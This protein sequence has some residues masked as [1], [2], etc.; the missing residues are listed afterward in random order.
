MCHDHYPNLIVKSRVFTIENYQELASGTR[1]GRAVRYDEDTLAKLWY[2]AVAAYDRF[3]RH[4]ELEVLDQAISQFQTIFSS[5]PEDDPRLADVLNNLGNSL[6]FRFERLGRLADMN[7]GIE[8][9]QKV[10]NLIEDGHSNKPMYLNNLGISLQTRFDR[11]GNV[12]DLDD[13]IAQKRAAVHLTPN[14][15]PSKPMYL[16]NLGSSLRSR[17]ERLGNL[18]DIDDSISQKRTAVNLTADNHR[19]KPAILSSFGNSLRI[20]FERLG[21]LADI[22]D[23]IAQNRAAVHLA[24]DDYP[25]KYMYLS[26]LGV[27]LQSR[28]ERLGNLADLDDAIAQNQ[29]VVHLIPANHPTK[30][31]Y[32]SNLGIS[33]RIRFE[34]LGNLADIDDAI[35]Q[36][37]A[38]IQLAPDDHPNKPV[39]LNNLA[40][41]F[42]NR[43][44]RLGNLADIDGAIAQNQ[45][46]VQL[47]P[48]GHPMKPTL[49]SNFGISLETRFRRLGNVADLDNAIA[50]IQAAVHLVPDG[51][52]KKSTYLNNLGISLQ[53]R[54]ERLGDLKDINDAIARYQTAVDLT[55]DTHPDK[56]GRSINLAI[57]LRLRFHRLHQIQDAKLTIHHLSVAAMN[58]VGPPSARFDAAQRWISIASGIDHP[59]LL[60]AYKCAIDL[61]PLVAWLGL[62][63]VDRHQHLAKMGGIARDAAAAAISLEQYDK[64]LE[65]LEQGRSVVWT[66]ILHLRSPVDELREVNPEL[67]DRLLRASRSLEQ[68]S[69][70]I[71]IPEEAIGSMDE[72]GRR[73]RA[74]TMEWESIIDEIR[75]LPTFENF[76]RPPTSQHLISAAR[77]SPV[78]ILNIAR[79]RCD[80]L[81]ILPGLDDIIHTPLPNITFEGVVELRDELK[82]FLYSSG[83]RS[84]GERAAMR[85]SEGTNEQTCERVLAE[86]WNNMVYPVLSSLAF[87]V[88]VSL[89][90]TSELADIATSSLIQTCFPAFG[91]VPLDRWRSCRFT[92]PV[93]TTGNR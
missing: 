30:P 15:H 11:L 2:D 40:I 61:I 48:D 36:T 59:S 37:E 38:A 19:N 6:S 91:G 77:N 70:Q 1:G 33:L 9:L 92:Q 28:F 23:A 84:R 10:I 32:L 7:E 45:A 16:N 24:P 63:L 83:V 66:Q 72:Q 82:D 35:R 55:P 26:S 44:E 4:G 81:A 18:A 21:N 57:S 93:Y 87:P 39:Y 42:R 78:V 25:E 46:A 64:A 14:D 68:G 62:P 52:P 31:M 76:L 17:F 20:R 34:R 75:S 54:F 67:A 51:H 80:A 29:A 73:Y 79:K 47:I 12:A 85:I 13:A 86:L 53:A 27:S 8:V 5:L 56:T 22:D 58:P 71:N 65:W 3:E 41:S 89:K 90:N 49:L 88:R 74:L 60:T 69:G 50:Q 43:F